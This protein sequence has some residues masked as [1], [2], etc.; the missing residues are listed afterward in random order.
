[1]AKTD[2]MQTSGGS[3]KYSDIEGVSYKW[4]W[5]AIPQMLLTMSIIIGMAIYFFSTRELTEFQLQ[6]CLLLVG[7][8]LI[9][10]IVITMFYRRVSVVAKGEHYKVTDGYAVSNAYKAT[11]K[12]VQDHPDYR[13]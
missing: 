7:S 10:D 6:R 11:L 8:L 4:T 12:K 9:L 2:F 3:V 1:M 5:H 13:G